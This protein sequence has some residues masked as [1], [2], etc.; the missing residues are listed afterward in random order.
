[1]I[2]LLFRGLSFRYFL[3]IVV[4]VVQ[5]FAAL[6]Q[7]TVVKDVN[8]QPGSV[9][10]QYNYEINFC[11]CNNYLYFIAAN[12]LGDELWRTDGTEA[13]T[14]IVLDLY[15]G[16]KGGLND[17]NL[18][19]L[20]NRL[21]FDGDDGVHGHEP[22][23]SDGTPEG[24]FLLKDIVPG[25]N[26]GGA[27]QITIFK[28][29]VVFLS[30]STLWQSDGTTAGTVAL[31]TFDSSDI[32][33]RIYSS[34]NYL[35][36]DVEKRNV[37]ERT[38]E[39][40]RSDGTA[41]NTTVVRTNTNSVND[42]LVINDKVWVFNE[43]QNTTTKIYDLP[44]TQSFME[45]NGKLI[46]GGGSSTWISDGTETG[47]YRISSVHLLSGVVKGE[48][49]YGAGY[50]YIQNSYA[51][52]R[53][54]GTVNGTT[55]VVNLGYPNSY[56]YDIIPVLNDQLLLPFNGEQGE[57]LATSDG[58][59]AGT[60]T[61]KDIFPGPDSSIPRRGAL[62]NNKFYFAANDG[63]HGSEIW[64]TDGTEAGTSLV[65]DINT[66]TQDGSGYLLPFN[67]HLYFTGT[68]DGNYGDTN[69]YEIDE[70]QQVQLIQPFDANVIGELNQNLFAF[71]N[72]M[73][74]KSALLKDGFT[75]VKDYTGQFSG[76]G[77]NGKGVVVNNKLIFLMSTSYGTIALGREPWITDGTEEGTH[78]L[79]DINPGTGNGAYF[80]NAVLDNHYIFGGNDGT[81]G[82]ELWK[83]D[84]TAEGT[85]LVKD[86]NAN[87]DS[88]PTSQTVIDNSV[89]FTADDGIHGNELWKTDGT[90]E[91]TVLVKDIRANGDGSTPEQLVRLNNVIVFVAQDEEYGWAL[92]K[93]DGTE[94]GTV[95]VKD[96]IPGSSTNF[97]PI[98]LKV[99][100][101]QLYFN[102]NDEIHGSEVWI[103]D[104]TTEG[105]YLIDITPG[106]EGSN[107]YAFSDANGIVY[108][109]ANDQIWRTDGMAAHTGKVADIATD[110]M[111]YHQG[112]LYFVATT[113]AYGRELYKLEVTKLDQTIDFTAV[114]A[115]VMGANPF[116]LNATAT[117]SLPITFSA[118]SDKV[119]LVNA[120]TTL[121]QPGSVTIKANQSGNALFNPAPEASTT[122]CI[123]PAQPV[124]TATTDFTGATLLTS[125]AE[126]GNAWFLNGSP[127]IDASAK[128]FQANES[129]LYSVQVSIDECKSEVSVD[130]PVTIT[131]VEDKNA[132]IVLS[133][134]PVSNTLRIQ[135]IGV[136]E[137]ATIEIYSVSGQPLDRFT[138]Q[139][140]AFVDHNVQGYAK[141]LY[142]VKVTS[143]KGVSFSKFV[144][145]S[146]CH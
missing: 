42:L 113:P 102:A 40:L 61:I 34:D 119:A 65:K 5:G 51:L 57:E 15:K 47:T 103:S 126:T 133:P 16:K 93:T 10:T 132:R 9:Q 129:G 1:M 120:T 27:Y 26:G 90:S 144:K 111:L 8:T 17:A 53:T 64:V 19:C 115:K 33:W 98:N 139:S 121:L 48:F 105:T 68:P 117:S 79:K 128:T 140:S 12:E 43:S 31:Q 104:G 66:G 78:V 45:Y 70:S 82:I 91:G 36:F 97:K 143:T 146:C 109:T 11:K 71:K 116:D 13:G 130:Q 55:S 81:T 86:I 21:Y 131:A 118:A 39:L 75:P 127:I 141:G 49:F 74:V 44:H 123:N 134:N 99:I 85:I 87:G 58:T 24:T 89:V 4:F 95:M 77:F 2:S 20:N 101:S 60:H 76:W 38:Y 22:W 23:T 114:P 92:W 59:Q 28:G 122:F 54:D 41:G 110:A 14:K 96:I 135:S 50:D 112:W 125:S 80:S 137:D 107:P 108:F 25:L 29:K 30:N 88:R 106:A 84:G 136:T 138:L 62:L 73:V 32:L 46:F 3:F 124:I 18:T 52:F 94:S 56:L 6:A 83:T 69:L 37:N 72:H 142:I 35:Y 145:E 7:V 63:I 67:D 100:G